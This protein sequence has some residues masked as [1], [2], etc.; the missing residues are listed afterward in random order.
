MS[1]AKTIQQ[2][3]EDALWYLERPGQSPGD[4]AKAIEILAHIARGKQEGPKLIEA[5]RS[6]NPA[7]NDKNSVW[8]SL[9]GR[10]LVVAV[11]H[12]PGGGTTGE[13]AWNTKLAQAMKALLESKGAIVHVYFHKLKS[14]GARQRAL[15]GWIKA[16]VPEAFICWEL[17]YD[18]VSNK[19]V[20]GHHFK[21]LGAKELAQFTQEEWV[22]NYPQ[23]RPRYDGGLHHATNGN[24]SGF[25]SA[26]PCWAILTEPFFN[27]NP[28]EA[29]FFKPRIEE[30]AQIYCIAAARF[31]KFKG[32]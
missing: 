31:A 27:S 7:A 21:H 17:H 16:N 22:A 28:A 3:I 5:I 1:K 25:L 20:S 12:E 29:A 14:Y 4:E 30:I 10:V 24:G 18:A 26:M 19:T 8:Q 9:K 11:G 6:S 2:Q 15:A 13:R 23:S 32:K